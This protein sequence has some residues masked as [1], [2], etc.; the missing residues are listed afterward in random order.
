MLLTHNDV[1]KH[2]WLQVDMPAWKL[3][4]PLEFHAAGS[5]VLLQAGGVVEEAHTAP[6]EFKQSPGSG[7]SRG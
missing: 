7:T 3:G 4:V 5:A 2:E 6:R 1:P